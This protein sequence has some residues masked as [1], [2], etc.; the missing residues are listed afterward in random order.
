MLDFLLQ[1]TH[2]EK[3]LGAEFLLD[4]ITA[5]SINLMYPLLKSSGLK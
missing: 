2:F 4:V 1:I 5:K 3:C